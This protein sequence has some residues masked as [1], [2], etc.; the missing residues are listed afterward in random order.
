MIERVK[1]ALMLLFRHNN[2]RS[3]DLLW[4]Q[5]IHRDELAERYAPVPDRLHRLKHDFWDIFSD[6]QINLSDDE[7]PHE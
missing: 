3:T 1:A 5:P 2:G 4:P 6:V 7:E